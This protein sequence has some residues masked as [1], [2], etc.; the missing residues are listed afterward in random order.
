MDADGLRPAADVSAASTRQPRKSASSSSANLPTL[1]SVHDHA[2]TVD[3]PSLQTAAL[4][5][6]STVTADARGG[7]HPF[8]LFFYDA[9]THNYTVSRYLE[10]VKARYGGIDAMLMW[11]TVS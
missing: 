4:I 6:I 5:A 7:R 9:A 11:P 10:D 2:T 1:A 3:T 8:D